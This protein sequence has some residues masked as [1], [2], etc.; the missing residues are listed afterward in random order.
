MRTWRNWYTH[1]L[2]EHGG[3]PHVG[4]SPT[5]RTKRAASSMDRVLPLHGRGYRFES[6]AAHNID[7]AGVAQ[8]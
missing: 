1:M 2:E 3:F 6:Y 7:Y 8:W 5:V 4:S